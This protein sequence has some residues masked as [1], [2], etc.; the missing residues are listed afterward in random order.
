MQELLL[1]MGGGAFTRRGAY[2]RDSTVFAI[3]FF[4]YVHVHVYIS[5]GQLGPF[6]PLPFYMLRLYFYS[7]VYNKRG[8][9]LA[10]LASI[11]SVY[12]NRLCVLLVCGKGR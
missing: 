11:Y 5:S 9:G 4:L 12:R 1:K 2:S 7:Y 10:G 6:P 3:N 8:M